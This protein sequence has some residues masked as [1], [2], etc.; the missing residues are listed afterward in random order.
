MTRRNS[1]NGNQMATT[2]STTENAP[3]NMNEKN[4][5]QVASN[6]SSERNSHPFGFGMLERF[7]ERF[8]FPWSRFYDDPFFFNINNFEDRFANMLDT[9]ERRFKGFGDS[10]AFFER[11]NDLSKYTQKLFDEFTGNNSN[12]NE[13]REQET[14]FPSSE[15]PNVADDDNGFLNHPKELE[16]L[17]NRYRSQGTEEDH[18]IH[19]PVVTGRSFASSTICRNGK[20]VTVSKHS[21]LTP[22]G[23]IKTRVDQRFKDN[24]NNGH[25]KTK[26]WVR[27]LNLN[28]SHHQNMI[29]GDNNSKLDH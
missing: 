28:K 8:G 4:N 18:H 15:D 14:S 27:D 1:H 12:S 24:E 17:Y 16:D 25:N 20:S 22:D 6:T 9:F 11:D 29:Q 10:S 5:L 23:T 21:E 2:S 7:S 26:S 19:H 13:K 3:A